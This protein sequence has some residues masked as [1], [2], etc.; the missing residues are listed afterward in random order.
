MMEDVVSE[1]VS[2]VDRL[3][4][5]R[6]FSVELPEEVVTVP[7]DGRLIVRVL[8]NLLENAVHHTQPDAKI[9]LT[10]TISDDELE[11]IVSD[12][13]EGI[14]DSIQKGI[15]DRFVTLDKVVSD[16]KRGIGLGLANCKALI[17]AHGGSI[18]AEAN[19]PQGAKFIFT[20]PMGE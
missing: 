1:A 16:G 17:E 19:T 6:N 8:I 7:M 2:H 12:T 4:R 18:R 13:G 14:D 3:L 11:I 5:E 15:F 20:L 9:K 10:A